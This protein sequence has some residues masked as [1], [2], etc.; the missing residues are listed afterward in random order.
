MITAAC[1][2]L[3]ANFTLKN[4]SFEIFKFH[5]LQQT[6]GESVDEYHIRLQIAANVVSRQRHRN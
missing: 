6:P 5:K 2:A 3:T 1:D 4:V